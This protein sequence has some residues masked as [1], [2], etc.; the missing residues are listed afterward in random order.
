MASTGPSFATDD[1]MTRACASFSGVRSASCKALRNAAYDPGAA[2]CGAHPDVSGAVPAAPSE[3]KR[4]HA[5]DA[6]DVRCL[7]PRRAKTV[8]VRLRCTSCVGTFPLVYGRHAAPGAPEASRS[9]HAHATSPPSAHPSDL[10]WHVSRLSADRTRLL[11]F[12]SP[13]SF[14]IHARSAR[15]SYAAS[16]HEAAHAPCGTLVPM[17]SG[18]RIRASKCAGGAGM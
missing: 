16:A 9:C 5:S 1:A 18:H 12:A 6:V 14:A 13:S 3:R 15:D 4:V 17:H 2:I 11:A 8:L 10:R 7:L